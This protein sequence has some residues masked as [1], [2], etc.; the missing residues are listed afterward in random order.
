MSKMKAMVRRLCSFGSRA[1][2]SSP[3]LMDFQGATGWGRLGIG[4][5]F[6]EPH[7]SWS[8]PAE[9]IT[10]LTNDHANKMG[11]GIV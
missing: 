4:S 3:G 9:F 11:T 10:V 6:R 5:L 1:V 2:Q 8:Q 7:I